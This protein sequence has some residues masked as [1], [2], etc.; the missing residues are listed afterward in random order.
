MCLP[1]FIGGKHRGKTAARRPT[2]LDPLY[3]TCMAL[4]IENYDKKGESLTD[5]TFFTMIEQQLVWFQDFLDRPGNE[6]S[7]PRFI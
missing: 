5:F 3:V 4:T 2:L 1:Y 6:Q 7:M